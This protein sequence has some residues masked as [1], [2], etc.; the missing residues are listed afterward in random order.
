[1][2]SITDLECWNC[3]DIEP[4]GSKINKIVPLIH[5]G[6]GRFKCPACG[7][8]SVDYSEGTYTIKIARIYDEADPQ[9][10]LYTE[11]LAF[12]PRLIDFYDVE[13]D[14]DHLFDDL[15]WGIYLCEVYIYWEHMVDDWD[16]TTDLFA[17]WEIRQ[18]NKPINQQFRWD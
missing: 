12:D 8:T 2:M 5:I 14:I 10:S 3:A 13:S 17:V 7:D 4:D 16:C 15:P 6:H 1:M 11:Y 9:G 18:E